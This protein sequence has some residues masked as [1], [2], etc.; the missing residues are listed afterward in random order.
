MQRSGLTAVID[1]TL[2]KSEATRAQVKALCTE[3]VEHR[4]AAACVS[5]NHAGLADLSLADA[6][7]RACAVVGF[8][9]GAH[10]TAIKPAEAAHVD[11]GRRGRHGD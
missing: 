8:P 5:P 3:A 2:L 7:P 9:R 1:H 4:F 10:P 11:W 6:G